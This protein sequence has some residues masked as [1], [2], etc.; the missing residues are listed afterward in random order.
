MSIF[1]RRL[2][3]RLP[4]G[5]DWEGTSFI[6]AVKLR[7]KFVGTAESRA[8]PVTLSETVYTDSHRAVRGQIASHRKCRS[9]RSG[10]DPALFD[11]ADTVGR[12]FVC[13]VLKQLL[14]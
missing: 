13:A 4:I 10:R 2:S 3:A 7:Y 5:P 8:L 9:P 6:R 1:Y 11:L 12:R 14:P